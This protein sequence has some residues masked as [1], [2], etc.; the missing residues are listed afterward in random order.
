MSKHVPLEIKRK[1]G[2]LVSF[3]VISDCSPQ[4]FLELSRSAELAAQRIP[5]IR[6]AVD[7]AEAEGCPEEESLKVVLRSLGIPESNLQGSVR[8]VLRGD[9]CAV[10]VSE[11][12]LPGRRNLGGSLHPEIS[13]LTAL[14][15]LDLDDSN[16]SGSLD[17]L[18]NNT[19]LRYLKLRH[20]RVTGLLEDL[21]KA[22]GLWGLDLTGTEVTGDLAA[23][24]NATRLDYL[25]LSNTAVSGELKSLEKLTDLEELEL[26]NTAVS[27]KL[28]SLENLNDL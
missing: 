4:T 6:Y 13:K 14:W 28:K 16:V 10:P 25:R 19:K 11:I 24:A 9:S 18:A 1:Q 12:R 20:A 8:Y 17:V 2:T 27:G 23:L 15:R 22:K 5:G 7:E 26:S 3:P 21:S